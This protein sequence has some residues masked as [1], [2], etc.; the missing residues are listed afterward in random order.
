[1]TQE[2]PPDAAEQAAEDALADLAA[3]LQKA[4]AAIRAIPNPGAAFAIARRFVQMC[5]EAVAP[6]AAVHAH[7]ASRIHQAEALSLAGLADRIGVSK[8]RADQLIK[9]ARKEAED[10]E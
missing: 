5:R 9:A 4:D 1:M 7:A 6:A 8:A 3:A 10:H 2:R